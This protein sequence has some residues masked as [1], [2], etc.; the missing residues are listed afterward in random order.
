MRNGSRRALLIPFGLF[1]IAL[2][3]PVA[4]LGY[5]FCQAFLGS[6]CGSS[7]YQDARLSIDRIAGFGILALGCACLAAYSARREP[8]PAW[9]NPKRMLYRLRLTPV[10]IAAAVA[11]A[12]ALARPPGGPTGVK[13]EIAGV[14]E[15]RSTR[16]TL[17]D[18]LEPTRT[19]WYRQSFDHLF[20]FPAGG[21]GRSLMT[22][23]ARQSGFTLR[24]PRTSFERWQ[25]NMSH[26]SA[27]VEKDGT[28]PGGFIQIVLVPVE[29][30]D[31]TFRVKV[32][33]AQR[34]ADRGRE[35]RF[36]FLKSIEYPRAAKEIGLVIDFA[37]AN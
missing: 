1:A 10:V 26:L 24:G 25:Q 33:N 23:D 27:S 15:G 7:P 16:T 37:G 28:L 17:Q 35:N 20:G 29:A 18:E 32:A 34:C 4:N 14:A 3:G 5:A 36:C 31:T 12:F 8:P 30:G 22:S 6:L 2:S 13:V 9:T 11:L 21:F 19:S